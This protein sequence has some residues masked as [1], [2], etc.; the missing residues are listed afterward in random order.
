[1][2]V[3][4]GRR[5]FTL[6]GVK[7]DPVQFEHLDLQTLG[8]AVAEG[9]RVAPSEYPGIATRFHMT[10]LDVQQEVLVL[11]LA[12]HHSDGLAFADKDAVLDVQ[13]SGEVLTSIQPVRSFPLNR[14]THLGTSAAEAL[15]AKPIPI[16]LRT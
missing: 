6:L 4:N 5:L 11:F 15:K 7:L 3:G 9:L 2:N 14:S 16:R 13:V 12:A 1:M 10:P 8:Q